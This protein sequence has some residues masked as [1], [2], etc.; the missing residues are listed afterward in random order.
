MRLQ[1]I[2]RHLRDDQDH[3]IAEVGDARHVSLLI[4]Q[5]V[6]EIAANRSEGAN[7]RYSIVPTEEVYK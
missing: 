1:L 5:M 2:A 4:D 3:V 7:W 6:D